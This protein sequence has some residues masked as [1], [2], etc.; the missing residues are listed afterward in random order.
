MKFGGHETFAIREG[1]LHKGLHLLQ[2]DPALILNEYASDELGVGK[3]MA[4]SIRYWLRVTGL[5]E[6]KGPSKQKTPVLTDF[7]RLVLEKD[8]YF[9]LPGTWWALHI[10]LVNKGFF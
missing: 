3:N 7:G 8:P 10:N 5:S 9:N 6:E 1:W 4:K 2:K